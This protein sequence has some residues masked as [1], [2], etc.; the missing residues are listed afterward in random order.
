MVTAGTSVIDVIIGD[1]QEVF[2]IGIAEVL[3]AADDIRILGKPECRKQLL[4]T[5]TTINPHVLILSTKFLSAFPKI[6]RM[7]TLRRPALLVLTEEDDP[8]AY[9]RLLGA[10]GILY[11][12]ME[13][14]DMV[15]AVRHAARTG[16]M[17]QGLN[18]DTLESPPNR[19]A[20]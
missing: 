4:A 13:G 1:H 16:P 3:G 11:R 5:L 8:V 20:A 19:P 2:R 18:S 6:M 9:M 14:P 10:R 17:A 7:L 15:D 12:S